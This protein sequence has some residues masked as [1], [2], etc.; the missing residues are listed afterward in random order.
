[1][2][3]WKKK[4]GIR[5]MTKKRLPVK[6][7]KQNG[8]YFIHNCQKSTGEQKPIDLTSLDLVKVTKIFSVFCEVKVLGLYSAQGEYN[9]HG[10]LD[11]VFLSD[12]DFY[13][14][15]KK[16][17]T[18]AKERQRKLDYQKVDSFID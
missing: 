4:K 3:K 14:A 6:K 10:Q 7:I 5:E 1:M 17:I 16:E 15:T 18:A 8:Y 2:K 11:V 13:T 12:A 9:P